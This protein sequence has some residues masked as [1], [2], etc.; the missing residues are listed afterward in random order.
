M[1]LALPRTRLRTPM[2]RVA[3]LLISMLSTA[4]ALEAQS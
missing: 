1:T 2:R 3:L 4:V